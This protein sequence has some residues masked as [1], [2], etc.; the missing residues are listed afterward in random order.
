MVVHDVLSDTNG[1]R[2]CCGSTLE[3]EQQ[4]VV[5]AM[6]ADISAFDSDRQIAVL[7]LESQM[8]CDEC[9]MRR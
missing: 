9:G 5:S 8:L 2:L 3:L 4:S 7:I 6:A 1:V